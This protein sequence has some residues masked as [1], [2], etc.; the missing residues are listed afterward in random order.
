MAVVGKN[1]RNKFPPIYK[2]L[3][4]LEGSDEIPFDLRWHRSL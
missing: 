1:E 3:P 2:M 4:L